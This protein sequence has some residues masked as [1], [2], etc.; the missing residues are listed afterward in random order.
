MKTQVEELHKHRWMTLCKGLHGEPFIREHGGGALIVPVTDSGEV[1]LVMEPAV[2]T[3]VPVMWLPAGAVEPGETP[4]EAASRELQEEV[5]FKA[6]RL[7]ALAE[8]HP[9]ARHA[10]WSLHAVLARDLSPSRLPG[11]EAHAIRIEPFPL[12]RFEELV[13]AGRLHDS[14]CIAALFLARRFLDRIET[15]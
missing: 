3:G 12:S 6:G 2:S 10:E 4:V 1:L 8:L 5:G 14:N 13:D 7:D 9:L 11:D 15:H